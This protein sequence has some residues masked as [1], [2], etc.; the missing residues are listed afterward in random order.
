MQNNFTKFKMSYLERYQDKGQN[1]WEFT[2]GESSYKNTKIKLLQLSFIPKLFTSIRN[3]SSVWILN[4]FLNISCDQKIFTTSRNLSSLRLVRKIKLI[5]LYHAFN[6]NNSP[7]QSRSLTL[8]LGLAGEFAICI[9]IHCTT[10]TAT[11]KT[12]W[13]QTSSLVCLAWMSLIS[14]SFLYFSLSSATSQLPQLSAFQ[15]PPFC[16]QW[17]PL[18]GQCYISQT[19][20]SPQC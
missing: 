18:V 19:P 12:P 2:L 13:V 8:I 1:H 15:S 16:S 14:F 11:T 5:K 7:T 10:P 9:V 3:R 6:I 17:Q 4:K 20:L